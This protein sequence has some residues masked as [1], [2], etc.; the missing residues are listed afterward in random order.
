MAGATS[1]IFAKY[2]WDATSTHV[3]FI[4]KPL[5]GRR[6]IKSLSLALRNSTYE[7]SYLTADCTVAVQ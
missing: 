7:T 4:P 2:V 1:A 3:S 6:E 5:G